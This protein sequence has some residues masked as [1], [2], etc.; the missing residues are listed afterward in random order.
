MAIGPEVTWDGLDAVREEERIEKAVQ[1]ARVVLRDELGQAHREPSFPSGVLEAEG[2][3]VDLHVPEQ[4][5]ERDDLVLDAFEDGVD[6]P[7]HHLA[8]AELEAAYEQLDLREPSPPRR[9]DEGIRFDL[10][11]REDLEAAYP[12]VRTDADLQVQ[13]R[14]PL[15]VA[16]EVGERA[17][18]LTL[19]DPASECS[20]AREPGP[21][22]REPIGCAVDDVLQLLKDV[23]LPTAFVPLADA[24]A[25]EQRAEGA[26][27][28]VQALELPPELGRSGEL[29]E[30]GPTMID[31]SRLGRRMRDHLHQVLR[32]EDRLL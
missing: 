2:A 16:Q 25:L 15:V 28:R 26:E 10:V 17:I 7:R 20:E 6:E 11:D 13:R 12:S 22:A 8:V 18:R 30:N 9:A 19:T 5:H 1:R 4:L 21:R 14:E 3:E 27:R 31:D 23:E 24:G 29:S 32:A